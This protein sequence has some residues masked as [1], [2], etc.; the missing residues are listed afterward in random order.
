MHEVVRRVATCH[1]QTGTS[2]RTGEAFRQERFRGLRDPRDVANDDCPTAHSMPNVAAVADA[3]P[4][5]YNF[6]KP[7]VED[8]VEKTRQVGMPHS[9][10]AA[11]ERSHER[12]DWPA[13]RHAR[14]DVP[15]DDRPRLWHL[16]DVPRPVHATRA[17]LQR[18]RRIREHLAGPRDADDALERSNGVDVAAP[19]FAQRRVGY[20]R[21]RARRLSQSRR[22]Q[23]D[24]D[25]VD[26]D[27][28]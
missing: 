11:A 5:S 16:E 28:G 17:Q 3:Y 20:R 7:D 4:S 22:R 27:L 8:G 6:R 23:D 15:G 1:A 18:R 13:A 21:R 2:I 26:E 25:G 24:G 10:A 12:H 19:E 9:V 14:D